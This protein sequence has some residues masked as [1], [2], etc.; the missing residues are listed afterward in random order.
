MSDNFFEKH[1]FSMGMFAAGIAVIMFIMFGAGIVCPLAIL[2]LQTLFG[3]FTSKEFGIL[4][5]SS[6]VIMTLI[7]V[8]PNVLIFR[9]KPRAA[10]VNQINIYFQLVCYSLLSLTFEHQY[11]WVF[12]SFVIFP[13]LANWLMV[14]AK[15]Q[16]F[17]AY[18][19]A[20]RKD[21]IGFR[22]SLAKKMF[23]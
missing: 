19:E 18:H 16:A 11:K 23:E 15:Y 5:T 9:G 13:L 14:S 22:R 10:K 17:L 20:L 8:V 1:E 6:V 21:P 2:S 3:E 12:L 7:I 4:F